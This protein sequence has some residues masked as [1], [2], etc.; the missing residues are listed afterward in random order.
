MT[1]TG[2]NLGILVYSVFSALVAFVLLG[3]FYFIRHAYIIQG[4]SPHL[5]MC[6]Q[7]S[8]IVNW[9]WIGVALSIPSL[10]CAVGNIILTFLLGIMTDAVHA[11]FLLLHFQIAMVQRTGS[12]ID[13]DD[14]PLRDLEVDDTSKIF[15]NGV[16]PARTSMVA[17]QKAKRRSVTQIDEIQGSMG[18]WVSNH[19]HWARS[20]N[21]S[22]ITGC[23]MA[24]RLGLLVVSMY[25]ESGDAA[26]CN[27]VSIDAS[28]RLTY[29]LPSTLLSMF[30]LYQTRYFSDN[31]K[32]QTEF[33]IFSRVYRFF[34]LG[35]M[36]FRALGSTVRG[37]PTTF[38]F[39]HNLFLLLC[40]QVMFVST[41]TLPIMFNQALNKKFA[42]KHQSPPLKEE[43]GLRDTIANDKETLEKFREFLTRSF[44]SQQLQFC[45]DVAK[46]KVMCAVLPEEDSGFAFRLITEKYVG[47][48]APYEV[49][50]TE[51]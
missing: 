5:S 20:D 6:E 43:D 14:T 9:L 46:F 37:D 29:L 25:V 48:D 10:G 26:T 45:E 24:V 23:L 40:L 8:F 17:I 27:D 39:C 22:K 47:D 36:L 7:L 35:A 31:F 44:A 49:P 15:K 11:R 18:D 1:I 19:I 12:Q 41:N 51:P 3:V 33:A 32:I 30:I 34:I 21:V 16:I 42:E 13:G 4:R 28:V 2:I 50:V 38:N